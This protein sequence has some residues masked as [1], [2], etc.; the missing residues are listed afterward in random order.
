MYGWCIWQLRRRRRRRLGAAAA[1][2]AARRS[3]KITASG[4]RS[5]PAVRSDTWLWW[6]RPS[7]VG[8]GSVAVSTP[9]STSDVRPTCWRCST[10]AVRDDLRVWSSY[11]TPPFTSSRP[12]PRTSL[13]TSRP[14][15]SASMVNS[16]CLKPSTLL[17]MKCSDIIFLDQELISYRYSSCCSCSYWGDHLQ[18][19]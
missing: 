18:K 6:N 15:T 10:R 3:Y 2:A 12:A 8:C 5:T 1:A 11:R 17:L 9:T 14:A 16:T 13:P 7:S 19:A 4:K